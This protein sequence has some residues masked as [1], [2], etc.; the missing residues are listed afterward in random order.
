[1][2]QDQKKANHEPRSAILQ[3]AKDEQVAKSITLALDL[4][5]YRMKPEN[6]NDANAVGIWEYISNSTGI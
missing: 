3:T 1:V 6:N 2:L 4:T 5:L